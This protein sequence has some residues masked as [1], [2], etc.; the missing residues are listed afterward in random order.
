MLANQDIRKEV[1]D[2]GFKLWELANAM[3]I[4]D[5]NLSRRLRKEMSETQKSEIRMLLNKMEKE[6]TGREA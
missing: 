6:R 1:K 2:K 5:G 4:Y 3:G